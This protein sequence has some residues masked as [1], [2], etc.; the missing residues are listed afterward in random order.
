MWTTKVFNNRLEC[1]HHMFNAISVYMR[2]CWTDYGFGLKKTQ[3]DML[4][5]ILSNILLSQTQT[6]IGVVFQFFKVLQKNSGGW[7]FNQAFHNILKERSC[8]TL[9]KYIFQ[10]LSSNFVQYFSPQHYIFKVSENGTKLHYDWNAC[11]I[12]TSITSSND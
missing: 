1:L 8:L 7:S 11:N 12:M 4:S 6:L 5:M 9:G 3:E 2:R 10:N